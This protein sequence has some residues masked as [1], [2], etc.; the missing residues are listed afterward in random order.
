[1][2]GA[3]EVKMVTTG[4]KLVERYK[5]NFSVFAEKE[6]CVRIL[7]ADESGNNKHIQEIIVNA[8]NWMDYLENGVDFQDYKIYRIEAFIPSQKEREEIGL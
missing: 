1:M 3:K 6:F 4:K 2:I 5:S 7:L 8:D